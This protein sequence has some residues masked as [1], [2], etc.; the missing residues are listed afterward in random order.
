MGRHPRVDVIPLIARLYL[1]VDRPNPLS[2]VT[3]SAIRGENRCA[4]SE[5][6]LCGYAG[7][8]ST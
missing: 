5:C 8:G 1:L 3:F 2:S 7:I 4:A 6:D